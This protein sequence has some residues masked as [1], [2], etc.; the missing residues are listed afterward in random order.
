MTPANKLNCSVSH[1][2]KI[3]GIRI[4]GNGN[5]YANTGMPAS[6]FELND[7]HLLRTTQTNSTIFS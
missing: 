6:V 4:L 1:F 2:G 5:A 7:P 3:A